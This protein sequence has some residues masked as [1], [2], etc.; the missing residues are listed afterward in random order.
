MR[1]RV[2][3]WLGGWV[4]DEG[5][6]VAGWEGDEG[7]GVGVAGWVGGCGCGWVGGWIG[8]GCVKLLPTLRAGNHILMLCKLH[9]HTGNV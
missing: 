6:G 7:V 5:E 8:C 4:G 1:V 3:V 2:W 9:V